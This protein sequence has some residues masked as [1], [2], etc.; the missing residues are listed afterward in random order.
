VTTNQSSFVSL[1]E[2]TSRSHP[3]RSESRNRLLATL[4]FDDY[5]RLLPNLKTVK[6]RFKEVLHKQYDEIR[7]VYFPESGACSLMKLM[8][9]GQ[10]AEIASIGNEGLIGSS[11]FFGEDRAVGQTIVQAAGLAQVMSVEAFSNE[12]ERQGT[13]YNR[14]IRYSQALLTQVM[15]TSV[16]N[17]LHT[18][19]ERCCRWLLMTTDAAK[20]GELPF[21]HE[22]IAEMLGVRRP[23]VTIVVG[24]LQKAGLIQ[25]R[26]GVIT[27]LDRKGLEAGACECYAT[28]K[29]NF[30]RLLPE[31]MAPTG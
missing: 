10:S 23:T 30:R 1:D 7:D 13:F 8:E 24:S 29:A 2:A 18:A 5:Q 17:G 27:I 16:C 12:M 19:E 6:L 15:Q 26:R 28:I 3:W 22:F 21:T 4:P 9:N 20:A 11:V 31:V 14:T 25:L